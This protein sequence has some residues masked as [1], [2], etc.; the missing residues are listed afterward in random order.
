M[1]WGQDGVR[2]RVWGQEGVWGGDTDGHRDVQS[3]VR[4]EAAVEGGHARQQARLP[5][6]RVAWG[7]V[8]G[9][10]VVMTAP[11]PV[12]RPPFPAAGALRV[13]QDPGEARVPAGAGV[14]LGCRV[15]TAEPWDL[16]R[17]EWVKDVGHGVLCAARL[18]PA[19]VALP[20]P[21]TPRFHLDD[22]GRYFCRVTLEIPRHDTAAGNGTLLSVSTG[23]RGRG[24]GGNPS[25]GWGGLTR[26]QIPRPQIPH[27]HLPP[28][29]PPPKYPPAHL[30]LCPNTPVPVPPHTHRG[31]PQAPPGPRGTQWVS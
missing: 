17:L 26:P 3:G 24:T 23:T 30:P 7:T 12:T 8:R 11:P 2:Q 25:F 13:S 10:G 14:A 29:P 20:V 31:S 22:A 6:P 5:L 15:L 21:C 19:A 4:P 18:R 28:C 9:G 1:G 16:L 27:P